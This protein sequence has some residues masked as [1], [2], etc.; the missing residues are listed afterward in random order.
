MEDTG[1][2]P[3]LQQ[4]FD[5]LIWT[6]F[7]KG[8][9]I[10]LSKIHTHLHFYK[11]THTHTHTQN[12]LVFKNIVFLFENHFTWL[13]K[14]H[15]MTPISSHHGTHSLYV[16]MP[17]ASSSVSSRNCRQAPALLWN[18]WCQV[19]S[20]PS[21]PVELTGTWSYRR[22]LRMPPLVTLQAIVPSL[23]RPQQGWPT[24][25]DQNDTTRN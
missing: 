19:F 14:K 21:L 13:K 22:T 3:L 23:V 6:N 2:N 16:L 15:E 9:L 5:C 1:Q 10:T 17:I 7:K 8:C 18:M 24:A 11:H 4:T 12:T 25:V 20:L